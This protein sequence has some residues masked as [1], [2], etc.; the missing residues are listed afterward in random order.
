MLHEQI[1]PNYCMVESRIFSMRCRI[2]SIVTTTQTLFWVLAFFC[3]QKALW[4][5][6][7]LNEHFSFLLLS[8]YKLYHL[9][10]I[11]NQKYLFRRTNS[12]FASSC[13]YVLVLLRMHVISIVFSSYLMFLHINSCPKAWTMYFD[14]KMK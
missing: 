7:W 4:V 13:N 8:L 12:Q 6:I 1:K 9:Q 11:C 14:F 3:C 2:S 10:S 5:V